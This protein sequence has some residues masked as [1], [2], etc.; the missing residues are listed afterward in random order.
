[1]HRSATLNSLTM[2][3][4]VQ[5]KFYIYSV[6]IIY[7]VHLLYMEVHILYTGLYFSYI[8][9]EYRCFLAKKDGKKF[10]DFNL[11]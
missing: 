10:L 2:P 11:T 5:V 8:E 9:D 1:M 6:Y 4:C 3:N 7:A